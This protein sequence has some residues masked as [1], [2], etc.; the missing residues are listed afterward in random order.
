[1]GRSEDAVGHSPPIQGDLTE[2]A[3]ISNSSHAGPSMDTA[4]TNVY[5]YLLRA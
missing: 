5:V 3:G 2:E 4:Y 1:M